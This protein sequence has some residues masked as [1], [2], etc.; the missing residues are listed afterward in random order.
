MC[1]KHYNT[2][3]TVVS[4][5]AGGTR[6]AAAYRMTATPVITGTSEQTTL[7]E[8]AHRTRYTYSKH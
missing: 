8:P 6:A 2:F 5:P 4:C 7:T 3:P 1:V